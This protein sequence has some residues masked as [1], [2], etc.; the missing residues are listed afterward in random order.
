MS[1]WS[2]HVLLVLAGVLPRSAVRLSGVQDRKGTRH[3][4]LL[5]QEPLG[6]ST[7]ELSLDSRKEKIHPDWATE[8]LTLNRLSV[9][10]FVQVEEKPRPPA[11]D[12]PKTGHWLLGAVSRRGSVRSNVVRLDDVMRA[13]QLGEKQAR[14]EAPRFCRAELSGRLSE[15]SGKG[16]GA[17]LTLGMNLVLDAQREG[18]PTA[19]IV[20]GDRA[21]FPPDAARAGVDLSALAVVRAPDSR[22]GLG[23]AARLARCGAFGL[24][25]IDLTGGEGDGTT[26][27][28]RR[29]RHRVATAH[30]SRL[31]GLAQNHDTAVLFLTCK[32]ED[33]P[34]LDSLISMR[35]KASRGDALGNGRFQCAME[36]VK[37]KRR[38]PRWKHRAQCVGPAGLW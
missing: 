32:T 9:F 31:V 28:S 24:I 27:R 10:S 12:G 19:W 18:E 6:G 14:Q 38:G 5:K 26:R 16:S 17:Q 33:Q 1:S 2:L 25:V 37:D 35:G 23:A 30:L 36:T 21:F 11:A 15:L 34:S 3:S 20:V 8:R 29:R 13:R 22:A 7:G 4:A